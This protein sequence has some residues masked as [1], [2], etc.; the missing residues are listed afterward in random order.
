VNEHIIKP[1]TVKFDD[2]AGTGVDKNLNG[3]ILGL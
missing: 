1:T 2:F 3:K